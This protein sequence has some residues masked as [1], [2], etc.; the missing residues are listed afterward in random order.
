[1]PDPIRK[2]KWTGS[3]LADRT[4]G[5]VESWGMLGDIGPPLL[6]PYYLT[7]Y[8]STTTVAL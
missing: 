1:M 4:C 7:Y 8:L 5:E 2:R 6:L 3:F